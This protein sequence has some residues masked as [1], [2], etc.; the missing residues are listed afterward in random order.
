MIKILVVDDEPMNRMVMNELL[1][2]DFDLKCVEDSQACFDL[3]DSWLPDLILMDVKM[4][5]IDGL[6][7]CR[8]IKLKP[9]TEFIPVIFVSALGFPDE[10]IAGYEAGGDDYI[11][12]PFSEEELL[13][14]IRLSIDNGKKLKEFKEKYQESSKMAM[15]AMTNT[16]EIGNILNFYQDSFNINTHEEVADKIL[17]VLSGYGLNAVV[18]I[19]ALE[20]SVYK[21]N[22]GAVRAI[23]MSVIEELRKRETIF[24]SGAR[25]AY[26]YSNITILALNMPIDDEEK[27]GRLRDHLAML[28]EGGNARIISLIA[29]NERNKHQTHLQQLVNATGNALMALEKQQSSNRDALTN[30]MGVLSDDVESSFFSL[31]LTEGQEV[32]LRN[33]IKNTEDQA[34][35]IFGK[36]IILR[37][38]LESIM[39]SLKQTG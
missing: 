18:G 25:S 3:L 9:E 17:D 5:G 37:R 4:P 28:A 7:A 11:V 19:F 21:S 32:S 31:G 33:I 22:I 20:E 30:I 15:M 12:K 13:S 35:A 16:A 34:S 36:D 39:L 24:S 2:P 14:K 26:S 1:G 23:E 27:Y 38:E 29:Q 10:R 6:E 8:R